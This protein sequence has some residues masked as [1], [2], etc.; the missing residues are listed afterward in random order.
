MA[1]PVSF[2]HKG[3][4]ISL[5]VHGDDFT[6]VGDDLGFNWIEALMRLWYEIKVR[7]RLGP[8]ESDQKEAT[9]LGR[10]IRWN[11][12]GVSCEAD[13][14]HRRMVMEALGLEETSKS[15]AAPGSKEQH[16]RDVEDESQGGDTRFRAIVARINYMAAD[17]PDVQFACKEVCRDMSNPTSQSWAKLKKL[18]RYLVGRPRVVWRFP[19]KNGVGPLRVYTDSDW[20]GDTKT[21]KS[22]SG[23]LIL[24]GEHCLKTWSHSQDA[25]ALSSCEAEYYAVVEGATR[26]LGM[27]SAAKELGIEVSSVEIEMNMDSSAAKSFASRRGTGRVKHIET[28]WLWLQSAVAGGQFRLKKVRGTCNPADVC[29][30]Y[31]SKTEAVEKLA[32]VNIEVEVKPSSSDGSVSTVFKE[33]APTGLQAC[34]GCHSR[35]TTGCLAWAGHPRV[36]WADAFDS[37]GEAAALGAEALD[38]EASEEECRQSRP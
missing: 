3:K 34:M 18:G 10:I 8:D 6:F 28:K 20:A 35:G 4:D 9:L 25:I 33:E 32:A 24:L 2:Y 13:P 1:S 30:K 23:G 38:G 36:C 17:M 26:A 22:T 27:K 31:L 37:E 11:R 21:R 12:W 5:T 19:W 14:K 29:T 15:L 16:T 7:A